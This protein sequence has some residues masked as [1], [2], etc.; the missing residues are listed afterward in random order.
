MEDKLLKVSDWSQKWKLGIYGGVIIGVV[1]FIYL[2]LVPWAS[3]ITDLIT[4]QNRYCEPFGA[5]MISTDNPLVSNPS[6]THPVAYCIINRSII[7]GTETAPTS[8][9]E[10]AFCGS[11]IMNT[12]SQ[13]ICE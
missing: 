6:S 11:Y 1:V 3:H 13:T 5:Q 10:T 2:G 8:T 12:N 9:H 7:P 4:Y